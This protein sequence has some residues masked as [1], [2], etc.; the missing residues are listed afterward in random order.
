MR[1][2]A[3]PPDAPHDSSSDVRPADDA[4]TDA[5]HEAIADAGHEAACVTV[6]ASLGPVIECMKAEAGT[7]APRS[8]EDASFPW[9]PPAQTIGA[10][11]PGASWQFINACIGADSSNAACNTFLASDG[12]TQCA[13][14]AISDMTQLT[15]GPLIATSSIVSLNYGGCFALTDPCHLACAKVYEDSYLCN[16]AACAPS[17]LGDASTV[18]D[19]QLNNFETCSSTANSCSCNPENQAAMPCQE[20]L[21]ANPRSA[22]CL[23]VSTEPFAN[24]AASL[25]SLFCGNGSLDA[26]PPDGAP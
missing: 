7:C 25:T 17:C 3:G 23:F 21:S 2:E 10:C 16:M 22:G 1:G 11:R 20:V 14:C 24:R 8:L 6:D 15:Y 26:G 18:T 5:R 12:G 4:V 13:A 9:H 19:E